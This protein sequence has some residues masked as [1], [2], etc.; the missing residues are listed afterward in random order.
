LQFVRYELMTGLLPYWYL[1]TAKWFY[2][3]LQYHIINLSF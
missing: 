3:M 1:Q 2:Y